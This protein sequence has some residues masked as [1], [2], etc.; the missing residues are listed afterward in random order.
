MRAIKY[1][2][3]LGLSLLPFLMGA[4][5]VMTSSPYSMFGVGEIMTSLYGSNAGMGGVAIGMRGKMLINTD[6][7]AGLAGLDTC[8]LFAEASAFA[9]WE[10]YQ[11][12]GEDNQ[13]FTGNFSRFALAGRIL[14]RWYMAG[15]LAPYSSVGYYFQS[16]QELEGSP[17]SYYTSTFS[18]DGGL[19]KVYLSNAFKLLPFL[20]IG[21]NL[22]YIFGN[23][24]QTE[25]QST[26]SVSQKLFGQSFSADFGVQYSYRIG[27]ELNLTLGAVYGLP[28]TIRMEKTKTITESSSENSYNMKRVSQTLP[29]YIEAGV[30]V[31]YRKMTYAFDYLFRQYSSLTSADSRVTFHNSHELRV[32]VCYFPDGYGSS[33]IWKRMDYKAGVEIAFP[34]YMQL[35]GQSGLSWRVSAGLGF[36]LMNGQ[37][38]TSFFY[39]RVELGGRM[40]KRG[41]TGF[42][43][44]YTLSELFYKVKL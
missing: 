29:Q 42:T 23:M 36:P 17:G 21:I 37:L 40:L 11:S 25:A 14:P 28:Q 43:V 33:S 26:M 35:R 34:Y 2:S 22:G 4:Q 41:I 3:L 1:G 12:K 16:T 31:E 13:T 39:D 38:H 15:G 19:S 5:N 10:S 20:S 7:P 32:G 27:H 18:G 8:R 6:N 44:T 9:K 24:T 30:S